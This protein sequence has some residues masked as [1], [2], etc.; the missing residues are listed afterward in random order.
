MKIVYLLGIYSQTHA[1]TVKNYYEPVSVDRN[2]IAYMTLQKQCKKFKQK[3]RKYDQR[4]MNWNEI[5]QYVAENVYKFLYTETDEGMLIW[6]QERKVTIQDF[7][8]I[9]ANQ[10][11]LTILVEELFPELLT[12]LEIAI[13]IRQADYPTSELHRRYKIPLKK[14]L[15]Q[16]LHE[17]IQA[18]VVNKQLLYAKNILSKKDIA[19]E[20]VYKAHVKR[21]QERLYV[22]DR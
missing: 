3:M 4:Q 13:Y 11:F 12:A 15:M 18:A 8:N 1:D 16:I 5:S 21:L 22:F 19:S 6:L 7:D 9:W 14:T 20:D 2:T 10:T 17:M